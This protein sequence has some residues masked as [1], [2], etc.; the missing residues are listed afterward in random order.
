MTLL[1]TAS[2]PAVCYAEAS[3]T[4]QSQETADAQEEENEANEAEPAE[5]SEDLSDQ[6]ATADEMTTKEDVVDDSMV[7]VTGEELNDGEYEI[8]VDS[9]SS[10][11]R[12]EKCTLTV[13]DGKMTALMTMGGTGY[14]KLFMG[15]G[16]E[17]VEASEDEYIPFVENE[18]GQHT[19]EVPVEALDKGLDC[20][21]FSKNKEKWY[22]RTLVF[23]A[24]SLP[25]EAYKESPVTTV[26][27]LELEDGQYEAE[28]TLEGGSGKA[29]VES[30][31]KIE[32]KDGAATATLI[33]S[34]SNYDYMIVDGEKYLM[35]NT[36]GNSTFEI[37][38]AGFD[39]K[40]PVTADTVAMST[41]HEIDYTL[42]FDSSTLKKAE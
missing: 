21:A 15:T 41:P 22:E 26:E 10:M 42:T 18:D 30:P 37:P 23:K 5:E 36:E 34:S 35:L 4:E 29:S 31:A 25:T 2:V 13:K 17:A 24:S 38:V 40:M 7:P 8:E 32:I 1:L 39:F 12:I 20:A 27:D 14:L 33:W 3:D 11:F 28:V 16:A 9:S 19:F 6:V